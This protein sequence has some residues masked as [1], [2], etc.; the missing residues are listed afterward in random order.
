MQL[1]HYRE[2]LETVKEREKQPVCD[3]LL[4]PSQCMQGL[5]VLPQAPTKLIDLE[6]CRHSGVTTTDAKHC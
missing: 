1:L 6:H 2:E 5:F 4:L 3:L